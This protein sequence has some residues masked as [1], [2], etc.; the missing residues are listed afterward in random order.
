M[1]KLGNA[2]PPAKASANAKAALYRGV[3]QLINEHQN[4]ILARYPKVMRRVSGYNLD[5][6]VDG[7]GYTGNIGPRKESNT[8]HRVWNL[9][10]LIVGSEGTLGF[11]LETKIRLTPLPQAT[12][13]CVIHF[14]DDL[15]ALAHIP[16]H[17]RPRPFRCRAARPLRAPRSQ[18]QRH[19]PRHGLVDPG[20][21]RRRAALRVL[22]R[23]PR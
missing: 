21:P 10:N 4:E 20:R 9:A 11:L 17:Q 8:N 16:R 23:H 3:K 2:V 13:V 14:K 12:G 6:F 15:D 1:T 18:G 5:E 19:H 22:R 7:A